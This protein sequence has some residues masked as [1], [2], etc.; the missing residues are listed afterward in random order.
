MH[1]RINQGLNQN[2]QNVFFYLFF[3]RGAGDLCKNFYIL[4]FLN[5]TS[6][7]HWS[8]ANYQCYDSFR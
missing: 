8:I 6:I 2:T 5:P 7:L 4:F 1:M 3:F